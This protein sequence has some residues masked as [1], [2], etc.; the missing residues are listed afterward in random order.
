MRNSCS[1]YIKITISIRKNIYYL[2]TQYWAIL[3][4][5]RIVVYI[6]LYARTVHTDNYINNILRL[7]C[8]CRMKNILHTINGH[9]FRISYIILLQITSNF[10]LF[11]LLFS[12]CYLRLCAKRIEENRNGP[13]NHR[14]ISRELLSLLPHTVPV[15]HGKEKKR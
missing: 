14:H 5:A 13:K 12:D 2:Y 1:R 15:L 6:R 3:S 8:V 9:V 11:S 4:I 7:A 10:T